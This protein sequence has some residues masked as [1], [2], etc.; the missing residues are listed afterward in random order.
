MSYGLEDPCS[1]CKKYD[2]CNDQRI[3]RNAINSIHSLVAGHLGWGNV[4]L[5]CNGIEKKDPE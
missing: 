1:N 4:K 2:K 3:I 5:D